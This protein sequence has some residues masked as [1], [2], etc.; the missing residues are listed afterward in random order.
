MAE[1]Y[2]GLYSHAAGPADQSCQLMGEWIIGVHQ[3]FSLCL[4]RLSAQ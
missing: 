3:F 4:Q 1:K 2:P